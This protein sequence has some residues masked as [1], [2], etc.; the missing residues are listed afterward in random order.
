M[1]YPQT[2]PFRRRAKRPRGTKRYESPRK[3]AN[4]YRNPRVTAKLFEE[5]KWNVKIVMTIDTLASWQRGEIEAELACEPRVR[6]HQFRDRELHVIVHRG[7][8]PGTNPWLQLTLSEEEAKDL[9]LDV[10][11]HWLD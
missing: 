3:R 2:I 7:K 4:R 6:A 11:Y 5:A 9:V 1:N 10:V 8:L